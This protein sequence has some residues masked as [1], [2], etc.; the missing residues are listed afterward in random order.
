MNDFETKPE[1]GQAQTVTQENDT[2]GME[3]VCSNC[4]HVY[5]LKVQKGVI[6]KGQGRMCPYC[7]CIDDGSFQY[8]KPMRIRYM[9]SMAN[10]SHWQD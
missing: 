3:F 10:V 6:A 2:Y 1:D 4:G 8:R 9:E 7:G 5:E